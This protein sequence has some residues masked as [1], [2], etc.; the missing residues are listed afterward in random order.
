MQWYCY[1]K[2]SEQF[3]V[4]LIDSF[5]QDINAT[6]A[7]KAQIPESNF[8]FKGINKKNNYVEFAR[9]EPII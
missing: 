4:N 3:D 1:Y 2:A 6:L 9:K 8:N 5:L 7:C